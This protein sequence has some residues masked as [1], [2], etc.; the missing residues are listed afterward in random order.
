MSEFWRNRRKLIPVALLIMSFAACENPNPS[1]EN[2]NNFAAAE[3]PTTDSTVTFSLLDSLRSGDLILRLG[4]GYVSEVMRQSSKSDQTYSHAGIFVWHEGEPKVYHS[5]YRE[6]DQTN[7]I[8]LIPFEEFTNKNQC[9]NFGVYRYEM[10]F[11]EL[12]M[13]HQVLDSMH[14]A[15]IPFDLDWSL[16]SKDKL[17]CSEM[18]ATAYESATRGRIQFEHTSTKKGDIIAADNLFLRRDCQLILSR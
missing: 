17:Y 5:L 2:F 8:E 10:S 11:A 7:A 6:S 3:K 13:L 9:R 12:A 16:E 15:K 18:V 14:K 4:F 1:Q